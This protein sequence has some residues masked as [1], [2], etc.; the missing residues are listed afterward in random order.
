MDQKL[1]LNSIPIYS[2]KKIYKMIN[3]LMTKVPKKREYSFLTNSGSFQSMTPPSFRFSE[4]AVEAT[5]CL[6]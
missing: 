1:P 5:P 3:T 2:Y 4:S 6:K